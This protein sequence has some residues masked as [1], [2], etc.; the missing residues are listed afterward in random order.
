MV[1]VLIDLAILAAELS[2]L[3]ETVLIACGFEVAY[4]SYLGWACSGLA[5]SEYAP[6]WVNMPSKAVGQAK[7]AR[8]T[9]EFCPM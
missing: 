5:C 3:G 8:N 9:K 4:S 2:D 1:W 6:D 7:S